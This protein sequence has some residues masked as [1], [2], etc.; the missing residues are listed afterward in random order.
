V[1]LAV[2]SRSRLA[3]TG[4][5]STAIT[6]QRAPG[7]GARQRART[8]TY[9]DDKLARRE[10]RLI[11]NLVGSRRIRKFCPSRRRRQ[12]RSVRRRADTEEHHRHHECS[13][14]VASQ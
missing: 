2:C 6:P 5:G 13:L 8:G 4:S 9:L 1:L 3:Q 10:R 12:S 7:E 11:D 14:A